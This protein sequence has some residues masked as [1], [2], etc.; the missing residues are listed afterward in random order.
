MSTEKIFLVISQFG[1]SFLALFGVLLIALAFS[2]YI[3]LVTVLGIVRVGL[4]S[5]GIPSVFVTG[6]LALALT[7]LVMAPTLNNAFVA[8]DKVLSKEGAVEER[9]RVQA[10]A[11][12]I[13]EWRGFVYRHTEVAERERFLRLALQLQGE[14]AEAAERSASEQGRSWQVLAPAFLVSE[15]KAAFRIGFTLFLPLVLIDLFVAN[16]LLA[17][18]YEQLSPHL[19]GFP[20]KILLFVMVDGWSLITANLIAT[21]TA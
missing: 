17:I 7:A 11:V 1:F 8:M 20:L 18:G 6:S 15:L 3:K 2:A 4:G 13:N 9:A 12:G 16:L 14:S 21:Y 19:I 5:D 10:L